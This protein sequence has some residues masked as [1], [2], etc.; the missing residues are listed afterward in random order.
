MN[1]HGILRDADTDE[2][3]RPATHS[4]QQRSNRLF[5]EDPNGG[6]VFYTEHG[7]EVWVDDESEVKS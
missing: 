1:Q 3:I 2:E 4:E 7:L 6:G 5:E